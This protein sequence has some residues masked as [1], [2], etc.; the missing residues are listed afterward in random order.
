MTTT[1]TPAPTNPDQTAATRGHR[2]ELATYSTDTGEHRRLIGQRIDGIVHIYD[3]PTDRAQ[4]TYLVEQGL[5]TNSELQALIGDYL[6]K[7]AKV[8]YPPMHGWF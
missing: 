3:E 8:G 1:H 5:D 4:P 2:V 7:A 6:A